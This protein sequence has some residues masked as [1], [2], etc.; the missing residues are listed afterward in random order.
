[1]QEII[2]VMP[3]NFMP[4]YEFPFQLGESRG[5]VV[6]SKLLLRNR[7]KSFVNVSCFMEVFSIKMMLEFS[8]FSRWGGLSDA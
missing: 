3:L 4:L 5:R 1:M 8:S 6:H 2:P 7:R